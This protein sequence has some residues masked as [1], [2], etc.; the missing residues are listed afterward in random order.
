MVIGNSVLAGW[1]SVEI[2]PA[3]PCRMG[4]YGARMQP[5]NA[6]HD[7]LYASALA[8]GTQVQPFVL[9]I[10]DCLD[11]HADITQEMQRSIATS[12][13][14]A[15][16]WLSATHTHSGPIISH[17]ESISPETP[18]TA[19]AER[20]IAGAG[21]A[22]E[23]AVA[24]MHPVHARWASGAIKDV[25]SNRDH[26]EHTADIALD[27]LC[28]YDVNE[29]I[30]EPIAIFGS[31]PCHPTVMS[32]ANLAISA[33][34]PG[35]FRRQMHEIFRARQ[36]IAPTV[37]LATGAAGDISTRHTRQGQDFE[38]LE[39]LG[40]LLAEQAYT[41]LA[42]AQPIRLDL[43]H[44]QTARVAVGAKPALSADEL[45][46]Y[47]SIIETS[48]QKARQADKVAEART[49][50]TALQGL[51]VAQ[52]RAM[53]QGK[54]Q[55][56]EER[57]LEVAVAALGEVAF[58]AVPGELYNRIGSEVRQTAGRPLLFLG[59]TNGYVGYIPTC[60]AYSEMDYEVLMSPFAPGTAERLG[61]ALRAMLTQY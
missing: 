57:S 38:E 55:Q 53:M 24:Q 41:L 32:A 1:A 49:L 31:F 28:F 17:D 59:Y 4:G 54:G 20:L 44:V 27:L 56:K 40:R 47:T 14:G 11:M 29:Q 23:D 3:V 58:A 61:D 5:A 35:A 26:P 19:A 15:T 52:K 37:A 33:D 60:E 51:Q 42:Q 34:L 22:A 25:A 39:R 13:P 2:T 8:L 30:G 9:I 46:A 7:P 36:A 10:C 21:K 45:V 16:V 12:I 43:P 50:E 48:M 18:H 6:I